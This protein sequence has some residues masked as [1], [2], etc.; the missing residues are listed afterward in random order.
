M[1]KSVGYIIL[2]YIVKILHKRI[3]M[4]KAMLIILDGVGIRENINHN[5]VAL[6]KTPNLDCY[7]KSYIYGKLNASESFVGL[8][9]GVFGN[10]EVGHLNIGAGRVVKQIINVIDNDIRSGE[11]FNKS[12]F[13][14]ALSNCS[15]NNYHIMGLLSDGAVHA[16]N[17]H[18][19]AVLDL[20]SK[21]AAQTNNID[22]VWLHLFLDGR[23]TPPNTGLFYMQKLEEFINN[24][25]VKQQQKIKIATISG[26]YYAMDRDNRY[27]RTQMAYLAIANAVS[28][29]LANDITAGN[30]LQPKN[31]VENCYKNGV[32]DEFI[33]PFAC[34]INDYNGIKSQDV[35]F[36]TN[37][38]ADR[39][40]QITTALCL[41]QFNQFCRNYIP[42]DIV[43]MTEY[44]AGL[45]VK[46]A[47]NKAKLINTLGECIA[48]NG[49]KQLR[50][51]ET[52]KYPHVT[53]FFSG[54]VDEIYP[55]EDRIF[56]A[57]AQNVSSYDQK[58]EMSLPE[59]SAQLI[60]AI[61][62]DEYQLIIANFANGDMVGHT[63]VLA[64]AIKAIECLDQYLAMVVT[65]ALA[66]NYH[67]IITAD[68]GN[69]E[70]M[71]DQEHNVPHTQHTTNL[72]PFIYISNDCSHF[73]LVCHQDNKAIDIKQD[74]CGS[75]RDIA[76]TILYL[77]DLDIPKD[78]TGASLLYHVK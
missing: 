30:T 71:Y 17:T 58:P 70:Q 15:G 69:S 42:I 18:Y 36:F 4:K 37:F 57:S 46:I 8:P 19:Y 24:L 23:D 47:Y 9:A 45:P 77:L 51:A 28:S 52:E 60:H 40:V 2:D 12:E 53:Y 34:K 49:G 25:P 50:I 74:A 31:Y 22:Y 29:T 75:L 67:I 66:K 41:P 59:L 35:I 43:T 62:Q 61:D 1:L 68:H 76:P 54:G 44:K 14:Q 5:A 56:V 26:R 78:M 16:M 73:N 27:E 65:A 11:F 38:R 32:F 55:N 10:S 39:A 13:I 21:Y 63:G 33:P 48:K 72:V 20:A 64:A 7:Q 6:A 3:N